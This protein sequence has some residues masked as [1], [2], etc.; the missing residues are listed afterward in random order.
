M[1]KILVE[2][3]PQNGSS[4]RFFAITSLS[5]TQAFWSDGTIGTNVKMNLLNG[6][7]DATVYG[8][9]E[10]STPIFYGFY[11][12]G[13][14]N[15]TIAQGDAKQGIIQMDDNI[16]STVVVSSPIN[17]FLI[18]LSQSG[19]L[20]VVNAKKEFSGPSASTS[21]SDGQTSV[22]ADA[23]ITISFNSFGAPY[24]DTATISTASF[25]VVDVNTSSEL[26]FTLSSQIIY[27]PYQ[28][29]T[30]TYTIDPVS[31]LISGDTYSMSIS[32]SIAS[33]LGTQFNNGVDQNI[34][35]TVQ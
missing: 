2:K 32:K 10:Q 11:S 35:F 21:P 6:L 33:M 18:T 22:A 23:N 17:P 19:K 4:P 28:P 27:D 31:D 26:P 7:S 3:D 5:K 15:I 8:E 20:S 30:I 24:L 14:K 13:G 25:T 9:S 34:S 1:K 12:D 29:A 16:I